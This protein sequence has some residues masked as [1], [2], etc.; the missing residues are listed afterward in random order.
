VTGGPPTS[1]ARLLADLAR[2]GPYS[3][4]TA[5]FALPQSTRRGDPTIDAGRPGRC[6]A[7]LGRSAAFELRVL[8]LSPRLWP[9]A[10]PARTATARRAGDQRGPWV[11]TQ[12]QAA[13]AARRPGT[14][15]GDSEAGSGT[16][17]DGAAGHPAAPRRSPVVASGMAVLSPRA[18][19][20]GNGEAGAP[21]RSMGR[22]RPVRQQPG[23]EVG[24]RPG[25]TPAVSL[26]WRSSARAARGRAAGPPAREDQPMAP[27]RTSLRGDGI[28]RK[29]NSTSAGS[30][31]RR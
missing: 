26:T 31:D 5:R 15:A 21:P 24:G 16:R 13:A 10:C 30:R 25:H 18:A 19:V 11:R 3:R 17:I 23:P 2:L 28:Q 1:G 7:N 12:R 20:G 9:G 4:W 29:L 27:H 6:G 14:A 8:P 22:A